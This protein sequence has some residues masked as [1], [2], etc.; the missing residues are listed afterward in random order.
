MESL[1]RVQVTSVSDEALVCG[2]YGKPL[3]DRRSKARSGDNYYEARLR[4]EV[5][6]IVLYLTATR[7]CVNHAYACV[8]SGNLA[9]ASGRVVTPESSLRDAYP[10]FLAPFWARTWMVD[11]PLRASDRQA[12]ANQY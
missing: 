8:S 2:R 10:R 7:R 11:V 5:D 9:P 12:A 4:F 6:D 3:R 1:H